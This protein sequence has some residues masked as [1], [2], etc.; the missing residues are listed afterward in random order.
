MRTTL[1]PLAA[2][3]AGL[4]LAAP[5]ASA[6]IVPGEGMAGAALG[7]SKAEVRE[8]LGSPTESR[9]T[10]DDFG[11][12]TRWYFKRPKIHVLFRVGE[13]G[14]NV[15]SFLTRRGVTRT[16]EGSGVGT[17]A[18]TL[19]RRHDGIVCER[20]PGV[21]RRSCHLGDFLPGETVTDFRLGESG[22]V[23]SVVIGYVID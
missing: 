9:T 3:V 10:R 22:R 19:R 16:A 11:R 8:V 17:S 4:L 21:D 15:T 20:Y 1:L 5:A 18:S 13:D 6:T 12:V 7:M 14:M 23:G 2:S